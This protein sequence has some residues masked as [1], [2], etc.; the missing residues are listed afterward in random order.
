MKTKFQNWIKGL[1]YG[2]RVVSDGIGRPVGALAIFT[3]AVMVLAVTL[4]V[5][6][7]FAG[8]TDATIGS[9]GTTGALPGHM[10]GGVYKLTRTLDFRSTAEDALT[11][12]SNEVYQAIHV[13]A[14]TFIASV[15]YEVLDGSTGVCTVDIGDGTD[16]DGYL[17]GANVRTGQVAYGWSSFDLV[18]AGG[19]NQAPRGYTDGKFYSANDTIDL[20]LLNPTTSLRIKLVAVAHPI[21]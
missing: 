20:V 2:A 13:P 8:T 4:A 3:I 12:T 15:G 19:T 5:H 18:I 14:G 1:A 16:P 17:D 21:R 7:A 10:A 11:G 6:P 9:V